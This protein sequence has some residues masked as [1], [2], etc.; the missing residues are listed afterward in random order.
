[1]AIALSMT[2]IGSPYDL[3]RVSQWTLWRMVSSG[4]PSR[5]GGGKEPTHLASMPAPAGMLA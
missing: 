2:E 1:M 4:I 3:P 5:S